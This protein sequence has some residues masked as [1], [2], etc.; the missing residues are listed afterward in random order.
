MPAWR[1]SPDRVV[2]LLLLAA[3][4]TG[5]LALLIGPELPYAVDPR[6][7]L[8]RCLLVLAA[9]LCG[10][11]WQ[12]PS[13]GRGQPASYRMRMAGAGL[14]LLGAALVLGAPL[15]LPSEHRMLQLLAGSLGLL[16][17]LGVAVLVVVPT[18]SNTGSASRRAVAPVSLVLGIYVA[19]AAARVGVGAVAE[20][21]L[22]EIEPGTPTA[23]LVG[24]LLA[25]LAMLLSV[26]TAVRRLGLGGWRQLGYRPIALRRLVV[27]GAAAAA[28]GMLFDGLVG[29]L[30]TL[31]GI[32]TTH[33]GNAVP[34]SGPPTVL[35]VAQV[36]GVVVVLA[37]MVEETVFRG[38]LFGLLA[39]AGQPLW[40]AVGLSSGLF[41]LGHLT[42]GMPVAQLVY[43]GVTL[44]V[45]G[46]L[47]ALSYR[48]TGSLYPGMLGH[49]LANLVPTVS[50]TLGLD[51]DHQVAK[52]ILLAGVLAVALL[53]VDRLAPR[54]ERSAPARP[55]VLRRA[56]PAVRLGLAEITPVV[57]VV[58][59]GTL[60][61][62]LV[63]IGAPEP[64]SLALLIYG[65]VHGGRLI[66]ATSRA[67]VAWHERRPV[68][69]MRIAPLVDVQFAPGAPR[70]GRR[71]LAVL[72]NL[73]QV[74][75]GVG[76]LLLAAELGAASSPV[77]QETVVFIGWLYVV[78]VVNL[79]PL[80]G[81]DG[82]YLWGWS[83]RSGAVWPGVVLGVVVV[84]LAAVLVSLQFPTG[85]MRA[86]VADLGQPYLL[87]ALGVWGLGMLG[88]AQRLGLSLDPST[89]PTAEGRAR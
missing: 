51:P 74:A 55:S 69:G 16:A 14:A 70:T 46:S 24:G 67:L 3:V 61:L 81:L 17:A 15:P 89:G 21:V 87:I 58:V 37:P 38:I 49:A 10:S 50:T 44:F 12:T 57:Q 8:L 32:D 25:E 48:W 29:W 2:A 62:W 72:G 80:A 75:Y 65:L 54:R 88:M 77:V 23:V 41:A 85:Y 83:W 64:L 63:M 11:A 60:W 31:F 53:I 71:R 84:G 78:S 47:L 79:L 56:N 6:N 22:P 59:L 27:V 33:L 20:A 73:A 7:P 43:L 40:L 26:G 34:L 36:V 4:V 76:L 28:V 45:T 13:S 30:L 39:R 35:G 68:V 1:L 18:L 19:L 66:Y 52:V 5:P 42:A 82:A 86:F 9:S